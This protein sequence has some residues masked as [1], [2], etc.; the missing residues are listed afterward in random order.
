MRLTF[1]NVSMNQV[2][3]DCL[4]YNKKHN[5]YKKITV[6]VAVIFLLSPFLFKLRIEGQRGRYYEVIN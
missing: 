2:L 5:I 3:V 1:I 6:I 4:I